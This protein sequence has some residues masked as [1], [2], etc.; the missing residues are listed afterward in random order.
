[1]PDRP[2]PGRDFSVIRVGPLWRVTRPLHPV[3]E[4][5]VHERAAYVG[6]PRSHYAVRLV[7]TGRVALIVNFGPPY[8]RFARLR[9]P[10]PRTRPIGS[11][12]S[13][14]EDSP[15]VCEHPGDHDAL[16]VELTPL[17]AYRLLAMPLS[18]LSNSVVELRDVLG[19]EADELAE[20]LAATRDWTRRFDLLDNALLARVDEGPAAA[21]Q[22][23][24]AWR[25]ITTAPGAA[26]IAKIADEVGW[27][28]KHLLRRFTQQVGLTPKAVARVARFQQALSM[29]SRPGAA[30]LAEVSAACG[31]YD[32][33]HLSRDFRELAGASPKQ[34]ATSPWAANRAVDLDAKVAV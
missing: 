14:L 16:R 2:R 5:Y 3:L 1:M 11:L 28:H 10:Q 17:G 20:R 34:C 30:G 15:G 12:F 33:A 22:V 4:P 6:G 19:R 23:A 31:F 8:T 13:G 21:P 9:D 7:P 26:P 32:Q 27:S 29:L 25:L 18:E 24:H